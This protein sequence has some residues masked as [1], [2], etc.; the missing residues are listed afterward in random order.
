[1]ENKISKREEN[2]Q[3][4]RATIV[5]AAQ[6]IFILKGYEDATMDEI[7]KEAQ[8]TK[9][10]V[11]QYFSSKGDLFFAVVLKAF[12]LMFEYTRKEMDKCE[13]G[14]DK[15]C[16]SFSGYYN[17]ASEHQPLFT[18]MT[19]VG[20]VRRIVTDSAYL[21]EW[22]TY[23]DTLFEGLKYLVRLG[24]KDGSIRADYDEESVFS[25]G[26]LCSAFFHMFGKTGDNFIDHFD[27]DKKKFLTDTMKI[28]FNSLKS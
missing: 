19:Q 14:Y 5:E 23:D 28:V 6:K 1:M 21:E 11:Y 2:K 22:L 10:T 4:K 12:K 9:R 8:F 17:Y 18:L 20:E 3:I 7:A 16:S 24:K 15:L 27:L 25:I 13:S 26:Y